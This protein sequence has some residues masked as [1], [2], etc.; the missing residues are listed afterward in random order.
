MTGCRGAAGAMVVIISGPSG[1]GKDTIIN[2]VRANHDRPDYDFIVT[3]TTRAARHGEVDGTHYHF[4]PDAEFL[5][6]SDAGE[7]LEANQ[8]HGSHW[9]GTPRAAVCRALERGHHAILKIDVRGAQAVKQRVP[10]A[11][12]IFLVPPSQEALFG[13]LQ[14]RATETADELEVRQRDAAIELARQG[15]YDYVVV[16]ETGEVE[17]TAARVAEIIEEERARHPDRRVEL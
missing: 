3:C 14:A 12:L 7:L 8:V 1:V 4:M 15:D 16:N 10:D 17:R 2:A 13:R 11:L 6:L 9:Y 5:A